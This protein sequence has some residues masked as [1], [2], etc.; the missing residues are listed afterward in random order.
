MNPFKHGSKRDNSKLI[1]NDDKWYSK[2]KKQYIYRHYP[3]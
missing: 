1:E 3:N 2:K